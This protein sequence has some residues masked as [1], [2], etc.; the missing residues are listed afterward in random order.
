[1]CLGKEQMAFTYRHSILHE[2]AGHRNARG[3]PSGQRGP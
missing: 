2:T 1:M 3:I